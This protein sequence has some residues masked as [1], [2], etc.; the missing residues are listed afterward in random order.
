MWRTIQ[1][2]NAIFL[3]YG[4]DPMRVINVDLSAQRP[5]FVSPPTSRHIFP[6]G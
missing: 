6:Q 5:Q 2:S 1:S 3:K 4:I